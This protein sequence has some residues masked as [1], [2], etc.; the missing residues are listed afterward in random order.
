MC[1]NFYVTFCYP[2]LNLLISLWYLSIKYY[3]T[4]DFHLMLI[5]LWTNW[6]QVYCQK[7]IFP[8]YFSSWKGGK[9]GV[10]GGGARYS[11]FIKSPP[12]L[13]ISTNLTTAYSKVKMPIL[14]L[15]VSIF[16]WLAHLWHGGASGPG[17]RLVKG[18]A[19][20]RYIKLLPWLSI[21]N[22][23]LQSHTGFL[24]RQNDEKLNLM[25]EYILS[26]YSHILENLRKLRKISFFIVCPFRKNYLFFHKS[27]QY[28]NVGKITFNISISIY[29]TYI[30]KIMRKVRKTSGFVR[31]MRRIQQAAYPMVKLTQVIGAPINS[32][33]ILL[34]AGKDTRLSSWASIALWSTCFSTEI[35]LC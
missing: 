25:D 18:R 35:L 1:F 23:F 29:Y 14:D 9:M 30:N 7:R 11:N 2:S 16:R 17:G 28:R 31:P 32:I 4:I 8:S 21:H 6:C 34:F 10:V 26:S 27:N 15:Y 33:K 13:S 22:Q 12:Y 24:K 5:V 20:P 19:N 3:F